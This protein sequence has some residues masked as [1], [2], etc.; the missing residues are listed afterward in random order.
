MELATGLSLD[1]SR[2]TRVV[3]TDLRNEILRSLVEDALFELLV[4]NA[5]YLVDFNDRLARVV[6]DHPPGEVALLDILLD[7]R[8]VAGVPGSHRLLVPDR[9]VGVDQG[10]GGS[11]VHE[12]FGIVSLR[13]L[14][15]IE[16]AGLGLGVGVL[17]PIFDVPLEDARFLGNR[18]HSAWP[19]GHRFSKSAEATHLKFFTRADLRSVTIGLTVYIMECLS[20]NGGVG[21]R[22][23]LIGLRD[24]GAASRLGF[25]AKHLL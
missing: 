1:R 16:F 7:Q 20:I 22:F 25:L 9:D 15:K 5:T 17:D 23:R 24:S 19:V 14:V 2:A 4:E 8:H 6:I 13:E 10:I 3:V 21:K 18:I 11:H 12:A